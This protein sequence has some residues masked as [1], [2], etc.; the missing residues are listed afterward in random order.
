MVVGL[1]PLASLA[2]LILGASVAWLPAGATP[3]LPD[4][5]VSATAT[6]DGVEVAVAANGGATAVQ[7]VL[8]HDD[9]LEGTVID[10]VVEVPIEAGWTTNV[11]LHD[12]RPGV[13]FEV[14]VL[15]AEAVVPAPG[16]A[17]QLPD[18][19]RLDEVIPLA[20]K[21]LVPLAPLATAPVHRFQGYPVSPNPHWSGPHRVLVTEAGRV[22]VGW[23]QHDPGN[24]SEPE[25]SRLMVASSSDGGHTFPVLVEV[26]DQV[27]NG[28]D[29]WAWALD[30]D[31]QLHVLYSQIARMPG[32]WLPVGPMRHARVEPATG[33]VT[34]RED[35]PDGWR[36]GRVSVAVVEG[37]LLVVGSGASQGSGMPER[38]LQV[39]SID[40]NGPARSGTLPADGE[41]LPAYVASNA[42]GDAAVVWSRRAAPGEPMGLYVARTTD[43]G[44]TFAPPQA[45][46]SPE[47]GAAIFTQARPFLGDDGTVH[48]AVHVVPQDPEHVYDRRAGYV[49]VPATGD[50]VFR[51]VSGDDPQRLVAESHWASDLFV[52]VEG[53]RVWLYLIDI[54]PTG[55]NTGQLASFMAESVDGGDTFGHFR[56]LNLHGYTLAG[57]SD[58]DLFPDGRPILAGYYAFTMQ[59][60]FV[61]VMPFFDPVPPQGSLVVTIELRASPATWMLE[62]A[63]PADGGDDPPV[64]GTPQDAGDAAPSDAPVPLVVVAGALLVAMWARRRA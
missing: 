22:L 51:Q 25:A 46:P 47:A 35:F 23:I 36:L 5:R 45:I 20:E 10:R 14:S 15:P 34:L 55:A 18:P 9:P 41:A 21:G 43:G 7:V 11:T 6:H 1:R 48:V 59:T 33:E 30:K 39:W 28:F 63:R 32:S 12:L 42:V 44:V 29:S 8:H 49:R 2:I 24:G 61:A 37:S 26:A 3:V 4:V 50:P 16:S 27:G 19:A 53:H 17:V 64:E 58:L 62:A 54:T 60:Q 13:A 56:T 40:A 52:A 38:D 57:V 31:D